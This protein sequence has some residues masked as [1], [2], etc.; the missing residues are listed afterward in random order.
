MPME[1]TLTAREAELLME[2]VKNHISGLVRE[3]ARTDHREMRDDLK[4]QEEIFE[5]I[6]KKLGEK[7]AR[8]AA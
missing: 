5:T 1:L 8:T 4:A 3:I 2:T 7:K 6:L